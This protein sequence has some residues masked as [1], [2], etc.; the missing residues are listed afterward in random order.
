MIRG[1][2]V[3]AT[4]LGLPVAKGGWLLS[5]GAA[6]FGLAG[7]CEAFKHFMDRPHVAAVAPKGC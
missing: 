1:L 4:A 3:D 5:L 6:I 2:E 7:G